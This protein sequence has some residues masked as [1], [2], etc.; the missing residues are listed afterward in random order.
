[1]IQGTW[2]YFS[3]TVCKNKKLWFLIIYFLFQQSRGTC[4]T[5]IRH[6][7]RKQSV[8]WLRDCVV[9]LESNVNIRWCRTC[10]TRLKALANLARNRLWFYF[11]FQ[12]SLVKDS[13]MWKLTQILHAFHD[14][15]FSSIKGYFTQ[16]S[17]TES[18]DE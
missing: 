11:F 18:F 16:L 3:H 8:I 5:P 13:H 10:L 6:H 2:D 7:W 1:M 15:Y 17:H 4:P 12:T 9:S 14:S